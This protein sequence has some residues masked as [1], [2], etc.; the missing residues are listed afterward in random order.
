VY[1]EC[2]R[3]EEGGIPGGVLG[4]GI[5][6]GVLASLLPGYTPPYYTTPGTPLLSPR[7]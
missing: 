2:N 5:P 7:S 3:E 1:P 6:G 4:E